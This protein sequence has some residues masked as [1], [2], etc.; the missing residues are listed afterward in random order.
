MDERVVV[1]YGDGWKIVKKGK[2][3]ESKMPSTLDGTPVFDTVEVMPEFPGG[4]QALMKYLAMNIKYPVKAQ[5][6][7]TQGRVIVQFIVNKEGAVTDPTVARSVESSLDQEAIRIVKAMP[8]W[9]PGL[10]KGEPVNVKFTL[11]VMFK[12]TDND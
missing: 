5:E 12:L 10:Q 3:T 7:G 4:M 11:P 6:A 9:T 2:K 8:A 1:C